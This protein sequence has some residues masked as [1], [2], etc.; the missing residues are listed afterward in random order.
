MVPDGFDSK[1]AD[2]AQFPCAVLFAIFRDLSVQL[3]ES[4]FVMVCNLEAAVP[5][6]VYFSGMNRN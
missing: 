2:D 4:G 3:D 1:I 5:V 6:I